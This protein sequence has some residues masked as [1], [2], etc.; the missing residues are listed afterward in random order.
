MFIGR[1]SDQESFRGCG[2]FFFTSSCTCSAPGEDFVRLQRRKVVLAFIFHGLSLS[3]HY[4]SVCPW[5][6]MFT[7]T[8]RS[9]RLEPS[10]FSAHDS[11]G[12]G[13]A[14]NMQ[15]QQDLRS[16]NRRVDA[17]ALWRGFFYLFRLV[18]PCP[19]GQACHSPNTSCTHFRPVNGKS[20]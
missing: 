18:F 14:P 15:W 8:C 3:L 13:G 12:A 4:T 19:F 2:A 7:S 5:K 6:L 9:P 1:D 11:C 17:P 10:M 20:C 16:S